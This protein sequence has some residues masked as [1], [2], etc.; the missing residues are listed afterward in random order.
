[1]NP[2]VR[3]PTH[4]PSPATLLTPTALTDTLFTSHSRHSS[5]PTFHRPTRTIIMS[6]K[7]GTNPFTSKPSPLSA[8]QP[9][10]SPQQQSFNQPSPP[11]SLLHNPLSQQQQ[12]RPYA[13][14]PT[15]GASPN[16]STASLLPPSARGPPS[17]NLS[18]PPARGAPPLKSKNSDN[19]LVSSSRKRQP[20]G[21][22]GPD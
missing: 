2:F 19:S 12:R 4:T 5:T 15:P 20:V 21:Y 14:P 11:V 22:F 8:G 10:P 17:R 1:M 13:A 6:R 3:P 9:R 16:S 7:P 18:V